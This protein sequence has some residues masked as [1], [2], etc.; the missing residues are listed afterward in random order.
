MKLITLFVVTLLSLS[1]AAQD[2]LISG[3][4]RQGE[5][6]SVE[7]MKEPAM[8]GF[9]DQK[10]MCEFAV[11]DSD[12]TALEFARSRGES[13]TI[14]GYSNWFDCQV[15]FVFK[16]KGKLERMVLKRWMALNLTY[17]VST[18]YPE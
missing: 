1:V 15:K 17:H 11:Q 13:I 18:C 16:E 3:S 4:D 7:L 2:Q 9:Q 8:I 14:K 10:G 12:L 5:K 6:C